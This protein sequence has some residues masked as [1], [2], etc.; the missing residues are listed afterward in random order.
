MVDPDKRRVLDIIH[1]ALRQSRDSEEGDAGGS[2]TG[3]KLP[4]A[5]AIRSLSGQDEI[6][7]IVLEIRNQ[8]N[9]TR[10]RHRRCGYQMDTP[11]NIGH[12]PQAEW[13]LHSVFVDIVH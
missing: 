8:Q 7:S 4:Q 12:T 11:W 6:R 9:N 5:K 10:S 1:S 2:S 13:P 3:N